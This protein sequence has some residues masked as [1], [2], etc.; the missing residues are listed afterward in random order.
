MFNFNYYYETIVKHELQN[1]FYYNKILEIPQLEKIILSFD[2][3]QNDLKSLLSMLTALEIIT[4]QRAIFTCAKNVNIS[5]KLKKG[6]PIGCKITLRK[7]IMYLFFY[8]LINEFFIK[9]KVLRCFIV[10]KTFCNCFKT[11]TFNL[12]NILT[13]TELETNY[14]YFKNIPDLKIT[15]VTNRLVKNEEMF[16]LLKSLKFPIQINILKIVCKSN[17]MAEY[18]LAKI[19]VEGSSPFFC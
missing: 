13:F 5:L 18:N 6:T 19:I 17:S 7:Q 16:F 14:Y 1:K 2:C 3:N 11:L 8:K 10:S 4:T 15:L 9:L 12:I